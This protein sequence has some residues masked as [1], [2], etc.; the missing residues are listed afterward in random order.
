MEGSGPS[1]G[2]SERGGERDYEGFRVVDDSETN[3]TRSTD[4]TGKE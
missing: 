4:L 2:R 3:K 1:T